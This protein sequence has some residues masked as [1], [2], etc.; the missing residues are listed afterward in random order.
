MQPFGTL[1]QRREA[2]VPDFEMRPGF[3]VTNSALEEDVVGLDV[4]VADRPGPTVVNDVQRMS[5][6]DETVPDEVLRQRSKLTDRMIQISSCAVLEPQ[7][8]V[9]TT[10][11]SHLMMKHSDDAS[12]PWEDLLEND[13][14]YGHIVGGKYVVAVRLLAHGELTAPPV[15]DEDGAPLSALSDN[16]DGSPFCAGISSCGRTGSFIGM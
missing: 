8:Q 4:P 15:F 7:D 5:D 6:L 9:P 13:W 10:V 11:S 14:L 16:P 2:E 3:V 12:A 1:L